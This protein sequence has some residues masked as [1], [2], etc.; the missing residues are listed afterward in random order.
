MSHKSVCSVSKAGKLR[1]KYPRWAVVFP[2]TSLITLSLSPEYVAVTPRNIYLRLSTANPNDRRSRRPST[3]VSAI[4]CKTVL[5]GNY[6][7]RNTHN[8]TATTSTDAINYLMRWNIT[9]KIIPT[10]N[11]IIL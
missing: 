10:L 4:L 6:N 8:L 11:L 5:Q 2:L 3:S 1:T 7:A 9:I